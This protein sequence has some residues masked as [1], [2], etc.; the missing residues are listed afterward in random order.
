ML[1]KNYIPLKSSMGIFLA[2]HGPPMP[3][4]MRMEICSVLCAENISQATISNGDVS[5]NKSPLQDD[6]AIIS[7]AF[8]DCRDIERN[9]KD[10]KHSPTTM[11]YIKLSLALLAQL[12][13]RYT[14][15]YKECSSKIRYDLICDDVAWAT[16]T[17][18]DKISHKLQFDGIEALPA[19]IN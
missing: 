13:S 2:T 10:E 1:L 5:N 11:F 3:T 15:A 18:H 4:S 6:E 14:F 17:V 8:N 16:R 9:V 19:R 7:I 12:E